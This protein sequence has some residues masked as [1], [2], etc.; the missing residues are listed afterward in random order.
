MF[1]DSKLDI[2]NIYY[3][4][5]ILLNPKLQNLLNRM[6]SNPFVESNT[7]QPFAVIISS[8]CC[9]ATI[10]VILY[11]SIAKYLHSAESQLQQNNSDSLIT[12]SIWFKWKIK[13]T[14]IVIYMSLFASLSFDVFYVLHMAKV[15]I[16]NGLLHV[17]CKSVYGVLSILYALNKTIIYYSYFLRL[18]TTYYQSTFQVN[19][20]L[21]LTL[22]ILTFI[23]F[24]IYLLYWMIY[25][26]DNDIYFYNAEYN[27]C[28]RKTATTDHETGVITVIL[29]VLYELFVSILSLV[30]FIKPLCYLRKIQKDMVLHEAIV[31]VGLLNSIIIIS[32]ILMFLV[33][34]FT[35]GAVFL[36]IDNMIN[37]VCLILMTKMHKGLYLRLCHFCIR[38]SCCKYD[39]E[40]KHLTMEIGTAM[41]MKATKSKSIDSGGSSPRF[42][43]SSTNESMFKE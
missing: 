40:D 6:S 3:C 5:P 8:V 26:P 15:I 1:I 9:I 16:P 24:I 28:Y 18:D 20:C 35:L 30:L 19:Q 31:K 37:S 25:V 21:L 23:Y 17:S 36:V 29:I 41:V 7:F 4:L 42:A 22:E 11:H 34:S 10:L 43:D 14:N 39:D 13:M 2:D 12:P 32:S 33:Y 27:Y 38:C